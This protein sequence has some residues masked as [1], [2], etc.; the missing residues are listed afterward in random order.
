MKETIKFAVRAASL[1]TMLPMLLLY[2]LTCI[3]C[4]KDAA[5]PAFSQFLCQLPGK[6]GSYLR[7]A[8]YRQTALKCEVDASIGYGTIFS[9]PEVSIGR[10]AYLGNYCSIGKV[11]IEDDVL[12]ASHVSLMNGTKQ[13]RIERLDVPVREQIGEFPPI[14]IG[15]DSWIGE[16]AI[17]AANV[18]KHC[19]VGAGALVLTDLPDYAIAVGIP[20]KIVG[21]RRTEAGVAISD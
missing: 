8:F 12:I 16:K 2:S 21:D 6:T 1:A 19:V 14:T 13:H 3:C 18:G 20:A 11:T 9:S 5:F 7:H 10:T 15:R 4:G 17:V